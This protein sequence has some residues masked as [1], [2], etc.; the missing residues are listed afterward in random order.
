MAHFE[1]ATEADGIGD[2]SAHDPERAGLPSAWVRKAASYI[3]QQSMD[4]AA[5]GQGARKRLRAKPLIFVFGGGGEQCFAL[6]P[7]LDLAL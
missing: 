6:E 5:P 2:S 4:R 7:V 1:D 3:A